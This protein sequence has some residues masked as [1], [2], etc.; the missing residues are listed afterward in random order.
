MQ[1]QKGFGLILLAIVAL[2][3]SLL[4]TACGGAVGRTSEGVVQAQNEEFGVSTQAR[5]RPSKPPVTPVATR[6]VVSSTPVASASAI[7]AL[8][9]WNQQTLGINPTITEAKGIN[10]EVLATYEILSVQYGLITANIDSSRAAY[11]GKIQNGGVTVLLLGGGSSASNEDI[12]IQIEK[13]S[14]GYT[15]LPANSFPTD[16]NAALAQLKQTFPSLSGYDFKT[17]NTGQNSYIFYATKTETK[18]GR[19]AQRINTGV[20][21]GTVKIGNK[22]WNYALV[23]TGEYTGRVK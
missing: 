8:N 1:K 13:G 19:P 21:I 11:A 15:Q 20:S 10:R 23:G 5:E 18:P 12:T 9:T 16:S 7:T 14:L 4:L 17:A 22:V 2:C 6:T 3:A